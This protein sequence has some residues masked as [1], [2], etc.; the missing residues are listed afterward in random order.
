[1][2][3]Q[4]P[5]QPSLVE[6]TVVLSLEISKITNRKKLHRDTDAV[7]TEVDR[8]MLHMSVDLFD[9][10]EHKE[11]GRYLTA[12]KAKVL[13]LSV[14]SFFRGGMYLV[15]VEAVEQIDEILTKA[16]EEFRPLVKAFC[17]VVDKRRDE[18][19]ERLGKAYN[20]ANYP[21][22]EAVAATYNIQW[23]WLALTTPTSLKK[24]S[25]AFF[26]KEVEKHAVQLEEASKGI[27][28]LLTEQAKKLADHMV[29]RL[30]PDADG[31]PKKFKDTLT[32]N[33]T[34]FLATFDLR[35]VGGSKELDDQIIRMRKLIEGLDPDDLRDNDKLREDTVTGFTKVAEAFDKIIVNKP[36]R[37]IVKK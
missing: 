6:S 34:E 37:F 20:A 1:M 33:I 25:K 12:T 7:D 23:S 10:L 30:T 35:N 24:I 18:S 11:I 4:T 31:K 17:D 22:P 8:A 5:Q 21:T 2:A 26:E 9:A 14:P 13:A 15:K 16:V 3:T 27:V 19:K 28:L 36:T 32:G 29:E